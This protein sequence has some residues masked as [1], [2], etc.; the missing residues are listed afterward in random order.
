MTIALR[1]RC[2]NPHCRS[3]L[4]EPVENEH[5]AFCCRG[6]YDNFYFTRCRVC[7]K[8][9]RDN[10]GGRRIYCRAPNKCGTEALGMAR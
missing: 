5:H 6:C 4:R 3:K 8:P 7:E 9:L 10:S 1:H 2:R